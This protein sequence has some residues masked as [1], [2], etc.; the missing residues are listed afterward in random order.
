MS[1][2]ENT[3]NPSIPPPA[4]LTV[5]LTVPYPSWWQGATTVEIELN[6]GDDTSG[7]VT[8][9]FSKDDLELFPHGLAFPSGTGF[10]N[11]FV[12]WHRVYDIHQVS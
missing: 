6:T 3:P 7:T 1:A 4:A 8:A 10:A 9:T 12:P 5:V 11:T 2:V